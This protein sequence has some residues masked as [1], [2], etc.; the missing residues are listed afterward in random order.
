M[1]LCISKTKIMLFGAP[2]Q[3]LDVT[4]QGRPVEQMLHFKYL[5]VWIDEDLSFTEQA[6]YAASKSI[7]AF[8]KFARLIE[9]RKGIS[10]QIGIVLYTVNVWS[11]HI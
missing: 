8:S 5:G 9:G 3:C 1:L 6:E 2:N 4:I 11:G 10:P 7:K